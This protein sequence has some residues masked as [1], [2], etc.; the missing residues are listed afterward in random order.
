MVGYGM[1]YSTYCAILPPNAAAIF[2]APL[3][4]GKL[5]SNLFPND[6]N[7]KF[8]TRFAHARDRA[9]DQE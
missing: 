1:D 7:A 8:A 3:G 9:P 5:A 2:E 6:N 4:L